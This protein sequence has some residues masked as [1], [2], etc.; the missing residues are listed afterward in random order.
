MS[1]KMVFH[2]VDAEGP[3][4]LSLSTMRCMGL[5][6]KHP[7]VYIETIDIHSVQDLARCAKDKVESDSKQE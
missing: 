1:D 6:T 7:A 2:I 3:V 4:L 5:F